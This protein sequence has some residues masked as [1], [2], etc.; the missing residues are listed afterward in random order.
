MDRV[1]RAA[2]RVIASFLATDREVD[3]LSVTAPKASAY[4][5]QAGGVV[6]MLEKLKDKFYDER[7]ELEKAEMESKHAYD[8]LVNQLVNNIDE[9]QKVSDTKAKEKA[10]REQDAAEAKGD[11]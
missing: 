5:F 11:L 2:K 10:A 8:M 6:E 7:H 4:E 9:A 1:P 3:P